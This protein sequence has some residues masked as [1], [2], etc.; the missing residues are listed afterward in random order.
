MESE[1]GSNQQPQ[2]HVDEKADD[3][4]NPDEG[5]AHAEPSQWPSRV[6][7]SKNNTSSNN[8]SHG[9]SKR[10]HG[11]VEEVIIPVTNARIQPRTMVVEAIYALAAFPA[12]LAVHFNIGITISAIQ[13]L[14]IVIHILI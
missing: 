12:M 6:L 4:D 2:R 1:E 10:A 9:Q 13:I 5:L 3:K 14:A 7:Y 11:S 8:N